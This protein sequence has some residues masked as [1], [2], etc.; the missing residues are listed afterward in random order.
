MKISLI[1]S[2][3][4]YN[5]EYR[6][7]KC[8]LIPFINF[9]HNENNLFMLTKCTNNHY[10]SKPF[11]EMEKMC[12]NSPITNFKC[13]VCENENKEYFNKLPNNLYYC[14]KCLIYYCLK[15]KNIHILEENHENFFIKN[16]DNICI[17]HN[18]NNIVG[19]CCNHNK[20]YCFECNHFN[21]NNQKTNFIIE[22]IDI[23][24][25]EE[26]IKKNEEI[27]NQ[28]GLIIYRYTKLVNELEKNFLFYKEIINK[29]IK[30]M[31]EI[32]NFYKI[33]KL[34]KKLNYQM[35][36]NIENNH[37]NLT[38]IH[39]FI[40]YNFNVQEKEINKLIK[41]FKLK[42]INNEYFNDFKFEKMVNFLNFKVNINS[43]LCLKILEDNR[44]AACDSKS[45]LIIYNLETFNTDIIIK[46]ELG[47]LT[48]FTQL[49]NK[50]I[51]CSFD[52]DYT[53]KIIKIKNNNDY[54]CIQII[55]KAHDNKITKIIEL[56]NENIITFSWDNSLK[57]WNMNYYNNI[58]EKINEYKDT[59]YISDGIEIRDNEILYDLNTNKNSLV[60]YN[61]NKNKKIKT[62][63]DLDLNICDVGHRMTK[64]TDDEV[65]IAGKKKIY[66]IDI[67]KYQI[68]Y[69]IICDIRIF[70]ILK[71]SSNLILTG[72]EKGTINKY[73][74]EN[75]KIIK[76]LS[77]YE[78][79][80]KFLSS[81][82]LFNNILITATFTN[83]NI[84]LW[85][86]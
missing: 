44:L 7:P 26:E 6:C 20:N 86:K 85:K 9:S 43:I 74:I 13:N 64:L 50:N 33:K 15:H 49:K 73:K 14:S 24:K 63:V 66:L 8:S 18:E 35:R 37:F 10:Y 51:I 60:F 61:L 21:E 23:K 19:Y 69:E 82:I 72:D 59:N 38:Q 29:K 57:I 77:K 41:Y 58:Y 2:N 78:T 4:F 54:E 80:E 62:L 45:N 46:N 67:N 75:K 12:K 25:Y 31:K 56:K 40:K 34:E 27:I 83:N 39:T 55:K 11:D 17:E 81:I 65:A 42:E 76:E 71:L 22:D 36:F 68:S 28:M 53:L 79:K 48:Y 1:D 47:W 5:N 70:C 16:F 84:K 52:N 32:I 30:F 3:Q